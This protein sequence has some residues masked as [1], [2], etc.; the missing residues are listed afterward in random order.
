MQS[1]QKRDSLKMKK[2]DDLE[3]LARPP[4]PEIFFNNIEIGE[5]ITILVYNFNSNQHVTRK[6]N[7]R[8]AYI[9]FKCR[10][11][12]GFKEIAALCYQEVIFLSTRK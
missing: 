9:L 6:I 4:E 8:V 2:S 5:K 3:F 1:L 12:K 11:I 7:Q 10:L